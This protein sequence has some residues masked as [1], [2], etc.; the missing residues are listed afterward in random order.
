[1]VNKKISESLGSDLKTYGKKIYEGSKKGLLVATT[2]ALIGLSA[3]PV[4]SQDKLDINDRELENYAENY[5]E[6]ETNSE[7]LQDKYSFLEMGEHV[8]HY[9][10]ETFERAF[11]NLERKYVDQKNMSYREFSKNLNQMIEK[12]SDILYGQSNGSADM[13]EVQMFFENF[14]D[15]KS[16]QAISRNLLEQGVKEKRYFHAQNVLRNEGYIPGPIDGFYGEK[17][18][19]SLWAFQK[20]NDLEV[21]GQLDQQTLRAFGDMQEPEPK[22]NEERVHFEVDIDNQLLLAVENGEVKYNIHVSTGEDGAT[23]RESS[24]VYMIEDSGWR[25]AIN[26]EGDA[27]GKMK[28]PI[29][30]NGLVYIHGSLYVPQYNDSKGCVRT[31]EHEIDQLR[32]MISV[33]DWV[34]VY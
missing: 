5:I 2:A 19:N 23:P 14:G 4:N 32:E 12:Y 6:R 33:G 17:T 10:R 16:L 1:M 31:Q 20:I 22:Y 11:E 3:S 26:Q 13:T 34:H 9:E 18:R 21:T 29:R 27:I 28:N 8:D 15:N 24:K 30:F 7:L 25:D